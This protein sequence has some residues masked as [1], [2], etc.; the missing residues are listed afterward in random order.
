MFI[1]RLIVVFCLCILVVHDL[2]DCPLYILVTVNTHT[3]IYILY[4]Y[5]RLACVSCNAERRETLFE[6]K[7]KEKVIVVD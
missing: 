3:H 6:K 2:V 1:C 4:K 7:K 5:N